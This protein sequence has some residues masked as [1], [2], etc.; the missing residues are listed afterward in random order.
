M[1]AS[2]VINRMVP[3]FAEV[4]S[5]AIANGMREANGVESLPKDV[6]DHTANP[7]AGV[8]STVDDSYFRYA[9]CFY[10]EIKELARINTIKWND[11]LNGRMEDD[12]NQDNNA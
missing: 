2:A 1:Q 5:A 6:F 3:V 12:D 7:D 10:E 4:I 11:Y 8:Q 9:A